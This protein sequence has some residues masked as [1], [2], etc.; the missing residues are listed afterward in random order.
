MHGDGQVPQ[1]GSTPAFDVRRVRDA[2]PRRIAQVLVA[3]RDSMRT[4]TPRQ[5]IPA[6]PRAR[7]ALTV[8]YHER[9][10]KPARSVSHAGVFD[11]LI[12]QTGEAPGVLPHRTP[13]QRRLPAGWAHST[14]ISPC[15]PSSHPSPHPPT[16][17]HSATRSVRACASA[18]PAAT[19]TGLGVR[20]N[21]LQW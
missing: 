18:T 10:I 8:T 20:Q 17:P 3:C 7:Q 16:A 13:A 5:V 1:H 14:L 15:P 12:I 2:P 6:E 9:G 4:P 21:G 11:G 19:W